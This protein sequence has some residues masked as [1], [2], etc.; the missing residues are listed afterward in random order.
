V[1]T[2]RAAGDGDEVGITAV[3][4]DVL[5]TTPAT[6]VN[7]GVRNQAKPGRTNHD[8]GKGHRAT[9]VQSP[10]T[11]ASLPRKRP[12]ASSTTIRARR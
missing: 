2:S 9:H 3:L 11:T 8:I 1:A 5:D 7:P 12:T 4:R 6:R 10:P